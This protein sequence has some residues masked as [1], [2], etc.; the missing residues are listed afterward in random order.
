MNDDLL[1]SLVAIKYN[2]MEPNDAHLGVKLFF[3]AE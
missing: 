1:D 3:D 2:G